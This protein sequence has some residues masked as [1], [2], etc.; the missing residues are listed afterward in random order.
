MTPVV[1]TLKNKVQIRKHSDH[2]TNVFIY[3]VEIVTV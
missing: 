2:M 1:K 3:N